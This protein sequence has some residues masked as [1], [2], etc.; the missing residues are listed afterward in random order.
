MIKLEDFNQVAFDEEGKLLAKDYFSYKCGDFEICLE[1]CLNGYD[2][3]IYRGE[4]KDIVGEKKCTN[5][6][7]GDR[8]LRFGIDGLKKG[9]ANMVLLRAVKLANEFHKKFIN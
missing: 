8:G 9:Q 5:F 7:F 3:A 2:V 6:D 4:Q 1:P